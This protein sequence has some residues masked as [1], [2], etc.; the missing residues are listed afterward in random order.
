MNIRFHPEKELFG[1]PLCAACR[2]KEWFDRRGSEPSAMECSHSRYLCGG[3]RVEVPPKA[4]TYLVS[5]I[6]D[7][8]LTHYALS[9]EQLNCYGVF[10]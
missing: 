2:A 6:L 9:Q 1:L 7:R 8:N 10:A 5:V 4:L 3:Q